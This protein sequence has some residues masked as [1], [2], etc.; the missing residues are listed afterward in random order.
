M[1]VFIPP[2]KQTFIDPLT[3]DV[4]ALGTVEHYVPGGS[5]PKDTWSDEALTT[6]NTNPIF[7]DGGGQCIIWGEGL[8][9]QIAR[10]ADGTQLWDQVTGFDGEAALDLSVKDEGTAVTTATSVINFVGAGVTATGVGT[11]ATVTIP[12][13]SGASSGAFRVSL[14]DALTIPINNGYNMNGGY[15][16]ILDTTIF[17]IDSGVNLSLAYGSLPA[18]AVSVAFYS[19]STAYVIPTGMAGIWS[20]TWQSFLHTGVDEENNI[21]VGVT[22]LRS[23]GAFVDSDDPSGSQIQTARTANLDPPSGFNTGQSFTF[24]PVLYDCLEGDIIIPFVQ[25]DPVTSTMSLDGFST[26]F[27]GQY[28]GP[29]S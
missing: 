7:L 11:T 8:Y 27:Q 19:P 15:S 12:G 21:S 16:P 10:R 22:H 29:S 26:F 1:S 25:R 6:L 24:G 28:V 13:G 20:F 9:R 23:D 3:G 14:Y 4:L 5:T 18:I 17:D 2:G